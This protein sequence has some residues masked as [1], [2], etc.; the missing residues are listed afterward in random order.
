MARH[1]EQ[2]NNSTNHYTK[3]LKIAKYDF[4]VLNAVAFLVFASRTVKVVQ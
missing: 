3:Y 1:K 2:H 4:H